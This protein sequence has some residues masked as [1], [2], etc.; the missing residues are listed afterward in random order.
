MCQ[1]GV[2]G[3]ELFRVSDLELNRPGPSYT[4]DTVRQLSRSEPGKVHWLIG[5]DMLM[6]LPQWHRPLE[7]IQEAELIVMARPGWTI[8]WRT[9]PAEYGLLQKNVTEAPLIDIKASG[10]RKRIAAGADIEYLT[11]AAVCRYIADHSLYR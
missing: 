3:S 7:L 4:I 10:I 11:P 1:L 5:A 8:D 2:A 6:Y 9:L